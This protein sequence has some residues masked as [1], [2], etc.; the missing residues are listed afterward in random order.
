MSQSRR[1]APKVVQINAAAEVLG[2]FHRER[3][4]LELWPWM[5]EWLAWLHLFPTDN[6]SHSPRLCSGRWVC[7]VCPS[8]PECD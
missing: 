3:L 6:W 1:Q 7:L 4:W 8:V 5:C 2:P